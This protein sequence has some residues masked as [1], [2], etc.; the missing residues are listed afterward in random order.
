MTEWEV[1]PESLPNDWRL[2]KVEDVK[3]N[4]QRAIITG[5]FEERIRKFRRHGL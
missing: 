4:E 3:S 1:G 2:L 5:P